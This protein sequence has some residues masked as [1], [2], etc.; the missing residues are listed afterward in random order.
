MLK[1][2]S[3]LTSKKKMQIAITAG[4]IIIALVVALNYNLEQVKIS[5]QRFGDNLAQI[6][7][8]LRDETTQYDAKI[9]QYQKGNITKNEILQISDRHIVF[10]NDIL[11]KY[12]TLKPPETFVPSLEL[13]KL[14]TKSQI[15]SDKLLK[16]WIQ[17]GDNSTKLR[18]DELLGRSF[19]FETRAL[20]SFNKAKANSG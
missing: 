19:E 18:S 15:E 13:F 20:D 7:N 9:V 8:D 4:V 1:K 16:D 3:K 14:S 17:T 5:G 11:S 12:N 10:L 6:Q 2:K